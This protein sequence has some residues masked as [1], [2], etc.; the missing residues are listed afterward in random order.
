MKPLHLANGAATLSVYEIRL[1]A[2]LSINEKK[3]EI[4]LSF[5][6]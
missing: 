4:F 5:Y 3:R 2:Q 1:D 6:R